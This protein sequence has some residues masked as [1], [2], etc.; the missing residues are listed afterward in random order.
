MGDSIYDYSRMRG[1]SGKVV[2][3]LIIVVL[4]FLIFYFV[5][6]AWFGESEVGTK[7]LIVGQ[8]ELE[9][10]TNLKFPDDLLEPNKVYENM[11]TTIKCAQDTDDAF[12][13]VK[14]ETNYQVMDS[15]VL[16]PILHVKPEHEGEGKSS[17]IYNEIDDC[18]YYVGYISSEEEAIFN[19]GIVVTNGI[20]NIDKSQPIVI[21]ITVYATQRHFQSYVTEQEWTFA[22]EEW[23]QEI[24]VYDIV[25]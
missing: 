4:S 24:A 19:T 9:V 18:Y 13:K 17:W 22:P 12:I 21:T 1:R 7:V 10:Q 5:T 6:S 11:A 15:H 16:F 23:K 3:L 2:S 14:L 25:E 20:N 8:V